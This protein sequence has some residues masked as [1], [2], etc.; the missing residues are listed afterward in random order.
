MFL[1]LFSL[2]CFQNPQTST[3]KTELADKV[4]VLTR[5]VQQDHNFDGL[6]IPTII[7]PVSG[8]PVLIRDDYDKVCSR[9][10]EYLQ[11]LSFEFA[12][13]SSSFT[14]K[15]A[16]NTAM[17]LLNLEKVTGT[18]GCIACAYIK[19]I[20]P[21]IEK[22]KYY[23]TE[24][25]NVSQSMPGYLWLGDTSVI[26]LSDWLLG[27]STFFDLAANDS[28][29]IQIS[30]V[31]S[32]V[33]RRVLTNKMRIT[34]DYDKMT[35]Q[36]NMSSKL[37]HDHLNALLALENLI[38]AFRITREQ[39][40]MNE[41]LRLIKYE[42]YAEEAVQVDLAAME[43]NGHQDEDMSMIK[44][45]D[46]LMA[47]EKGAALRDL[48]KTAMRRNWMAFQYLHHPYYDFVMERHLREGIDS[49]T[50]NS[51]LEYKGEPESRKQ[52]IRTNEGDIEIDG[53]WQDAPSQFLLAYWYG[54]YHQLIEKA[55][56]L[57]DMNT[58]ARPDVPIL[59]QPG[60]PPPS[61]P[62]DLE[63]M[64]KVSASPFQMGSDEGDRDEGPLRK[65]VLPVFWIDK[66]LVTNLQYTRFDKTWVYPDGKD[67]CP[68]LVNWN[69]A[70]S[71]AKYFG[72]RLL[73]EQEWEKAARGTDGRVFPWGNIYDIGI[74]AAKNADPQGRV[75]ACISPYGCVDMVGNVCQWTSS[76]YAAYSDS[77]FHRILFEQKY[78][79]IRGSTATADRSH[80]RCAHR[81]FSSPRTIANLTVGFRCVQNKPPPN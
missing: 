66:Y 73:T 8:S 59:I 76:W 81:Y 46:R 31:V 30:A 9:T 44:A 37:P 33:M 75:T 60:T 77:K 56:L 52:K 3:T 67:L 53:T 38:C 5:R 80:H 58:P 4:L 18:P 15:S 20:K 21:G 22:R 72:K 6:I 39:S 1:L 34:D 7:C 63:S 11:S 50:L 55:A 14:R 71:Y 40:F 27:L 28:E 29:K 16:V 48:F 70:A 36:G 79:V 69:Q 10:G 12:T 74:V 62:L 13:T 42:H 64:V 57:H 32:R 54:R 43:R 51:L 19:S 26:Q 78:H 41:Y 65:E 2:I 47:Y 35:L 68:A 23:N 49:H 17:A 61:I 24:K 25:W 45:L